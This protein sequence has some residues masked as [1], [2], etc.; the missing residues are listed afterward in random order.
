MADSVGEAGESRVARRR[1]EREAAKK[2][3]EDGEGATG[4]AAK[5]T[6]GRFKD[7]KGK[8]REKRR[9]TGVITLVGQEVV[10]EAGMDDEVRA[11]TEINETIAT[12]KE[13]SISSHK[14]SCRSHDVPTTNLDVPIIT[15]PD[16]SMVTSSD[17]SMGTS[18]V[19]IVISPDVSIV[20]TTQETDKLEKDSDKPLGKR[21]NDSDKQL[22]HLA[23]EDDSPVEH[24]EKE[25]DSPVKHL[26]KE[27]DKSL[28]FEQSLEDNN[29][30]QTNM[31]DSKEKLNAIQMEKD[32]EETIETEETSN[33]TEAGDISAGPEAKNSLT[34]LTLADV[35]QSLSRTHDA[36]TDVQ[37][38]RTRRAWRTRQC[39]SLI[40]TDPNDLHTMYLPPDSPTENYKKLYDRERRETRR[41][42][43]RLAESEQAVNRMH[44]EMERLKKYLVD[45]ENEIDR[46][47]E[48]NDALVSAVT[49]LSL[50]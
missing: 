35:P 20:T 50:S 39:Q 37:S 14:S 12:D 8:V 23:K 41:L 44:E 45:A 17:V 15:S 27:S 38:P 43:R 28:G 22:E 34:A 11:N 36:Q 21:E 24:L 32:K 13:G 1:R 9:P 33:I 18:D 30:E 48:E 40:S 26:E 29:N 3:G 42:T 47:Q 49:K 6:G 19:S 7:R 2:N 16:I 5:K 46:L 31:V 4:G 25:D 10:Q